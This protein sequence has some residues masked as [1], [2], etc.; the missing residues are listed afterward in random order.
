MD[1]LLYQTQALEKDHFKAL[2]THHW[3]WDLAEQALLFIFSDLS[4]SSHQVHSVLTASGE[5]SA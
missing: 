1:H 3:S 5:K 4:L 2:F